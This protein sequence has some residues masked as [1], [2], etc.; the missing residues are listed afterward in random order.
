MTRVTNFGRKRKYLEAGFATDLTTTSTEQPGANTADDD[1][2]DA[3]PP[4]EKRKRTKKP[5]VDGG[6]EQT[7]SGVEAEGEASGQGKREGPSVG[8]K[9]ATMREKPKSGRTK[10]EHCIL[11]FAVQG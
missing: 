5:K 7:S 2:A 8:Q 6:D 11:S 9:K 3:V 1:Q 10:S 4:K